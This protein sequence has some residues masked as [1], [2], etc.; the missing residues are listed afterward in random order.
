MSKVLLIEDDEAV[1]T[2]YKRVFSLEG[3]DIEIAD[4]GQAGLDKVGVFQP[5]IIL[6]DM[7]MP[8][9]NGL[10][11]L[12]R[13]KADSTT[14]Q[15]PVIALTNVSELRITE[16]ALSL[17]ANLYL[18]KSDTEPDNAVQIVRDMLSKYGS[19]TATAPSPVP[20]P[21]T[22]PEAS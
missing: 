12:R 3:F 2:L 8:G 22:P 13:L 21:P 14:S 9:M 19:G 20:T 4:G 16:D 15:I 17:G 18:S 11:V 6:L 10:E 1:Q 7:M 5:D